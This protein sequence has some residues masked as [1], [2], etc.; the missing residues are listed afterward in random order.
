VA[1]TIFL[2][3]Q[4]LLPR[5]PPP[6]REPFPG[7][8]NECPVALFYLEEVATKQTHALIGIYM[9]VYHFGRLNARQQSPIGAFCGLDF[10]ANLS[11]N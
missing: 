2:T 3:N 4:S 6:V 8:I 9:W 10:K 1:G 7:A 11:S 5:K